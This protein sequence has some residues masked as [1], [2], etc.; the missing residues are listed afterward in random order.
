MTGLVLGVVGIA[1]GAA[2]AVVALLGEHGVFARLDVHRLLPHRGRARRGHRLRDLPDQP[3]STSSAG[4]GVEPREAARLAASPGLGVII[5]SALTVI[6]ANACLALA[7]VGLFRTT[8]PAIAVSVALDP[9]RSPS[10]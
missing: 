1:L 8:G 3:L 6:L 10:P 9:R 5:G 2:R 7:D 4:A